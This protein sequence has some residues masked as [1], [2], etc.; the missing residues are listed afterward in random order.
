MHF[1]P[2]G[3]LKI[4]KS[5]V[6][7]SILRFSQCSTSASKYH[8]PGLLLGH[9]SGPAGIE[10]VPWPRY[11]TLR[12]LCPS[13]SGP[14]ASKGSK[15]CSKWLPNG[16]PNHQK[17]DL[18]RIQNPWFGLKIGPQACQHRSG[19]FETGLRHS[20]APLRSQTNQKKKKYA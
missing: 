19:A 5:A 2:T 15:S 3:T 10:K 16:I 7:S 18:I 14:H 11:K 12:K 8:S 4:I 9:F 1:H 13:K 17:I 20:K 6:L